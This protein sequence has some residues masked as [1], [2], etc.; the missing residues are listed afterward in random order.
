MAEQ[1]L[2]TDDIYNIFSQELS[3]EK[4]ELLLSSIEKTISMP[5]SIHQQ[6]FLTFLSD[7]FPFLK[8]AKGL[9]ISLSP[10]VIH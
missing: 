9:K 10:C 5:D 1:S 2:S 3:F 8:I 4:P 6:N 7:N